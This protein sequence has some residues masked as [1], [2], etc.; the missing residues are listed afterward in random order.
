MGSKLTLFV[1]E[2]NMLHMLVFGLGFCF[3][4]LFWIKIRTKRTKLEYDIT[5]VMFFFLSQRQFWGCRVS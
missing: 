3:S 5:K 4:V 2:S 1:R